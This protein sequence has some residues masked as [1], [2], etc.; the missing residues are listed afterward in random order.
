MLGRLTRF[1]NPVNDSRGERKESTKLLKTIE[2]NS[3]VQRDEIC[4][5]DTKNTQVE[6]N[7]NVDVKV[8]S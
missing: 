1:C 2:D 4:P 5:N 8:E 3:S 6:V 7:E